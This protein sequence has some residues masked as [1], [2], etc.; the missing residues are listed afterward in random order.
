MPPLTVLD[1][2]FLLICQLALAAGA[3]LSPASA[4]ATTC[5]AHVRF[6]RDYS[7]ADNPCPL[8]KD[9]SRTPPRSC[10]GPGCSRGSDSL[11]A[12]TVAPHLL[13]QQWAAL[14]GRLV[15]AGPEAES[16]ANPAGL[17]RPIHRVFP[18]DPP[19]RAR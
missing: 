12:P 18:P 8:G 19:P 6:S 11:P 2:P 10:Y 17:V 14:A 13:I 16:A 15:V 5:G 9:C 7:R 4:A 3:L 1:R